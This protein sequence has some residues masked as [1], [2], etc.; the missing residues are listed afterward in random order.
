MEASRLCRVAPRVADQWP[1]MTASQSSRRPPVQGRATLTG[2]T[3]TWTGICDGGVARRA[4]CVDCDREMHKAIRRLQEGMQSVEARELLSNSFSPSSLPHPLRSRNH[5]SINLLAGTGMERMKDNN[6]QHVRTRHSSS[7][8]G[9]FQ[10]T[11]PRHVP[12]PFSSHKFLDGEINSEA[13]EGRKTKG[14]QSK[15]NAALDNQLFRISLR[16]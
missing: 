6:Q 10:E 13:W 3:T 8:H 11:V 5:K 9:T 7:T 4:D 2:L 15:E 16:P 1:G 12:L 14:R